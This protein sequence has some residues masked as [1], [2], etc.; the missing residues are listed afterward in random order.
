MAAKT[1]KKIQNREITPLWYMLDI[2]NVLPIATEL[3]VENPVDVTNY[4]WRHYDVT[5]TK[6]CIL[7]KV[8]WP[9]FNTKCYWYYS[10]HSYNFKQLCS[11][12]HSFYMYIFCRTVTMTS[13][14][15]H[16][17]EFFRCNRFI[18]HYRHTSSVRYIPT[19]VTRS[20]S[21]AFPCLNLV[22]HTEWVIPRRIRSRW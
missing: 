13:T 12:C 22:I 20:Q 5:L 7:A 15:Y 4:S 6:W 21:I 10:N 14:S 16:M 1:M 19:P 8:H 17:Q 9:K 2:I 3:I 18:H 11:R